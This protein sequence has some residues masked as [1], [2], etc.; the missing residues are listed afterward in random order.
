MKENMSEG[1]SSWWNQTRAA[2]ARI[3]GHVEVRQVGLSA[4]RLADSHSQADAVV[5]PA[6]AAGARENGW[7]PATGTQKWQPPAVSL[8]GGDLNEAALPCLVSGSLVPHLPET[9]VQREEARF[10]APTIWAADIGT[11]SSGAAAVLPASVRLSGGQVCLLSAA[12][13]VPPVHAV[14]VELSGRSRLG[15]VRDKRSGIPIFGAPRTWSRLDRIT[16][17]PL[18]RRRTALRAGAGVEGRFLAERQAL[19]ASCGATV[20]EVQLVASFPHVPL[21]LVQQMAVTPDGNALRLWLRPEALASGGAWT[22]A[23]VTIVLGRRRLTGET[24]RTVL[25]EAPTA[26][27]KR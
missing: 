6:P 5:W 26:G 22:A 15:A 8:A 14:S 7:L 23:R 1:S 18:L 4:P 20:E 11:N 17:V 13:L 19:A 12:L 16:R 2:L 9:G 10:P 27:R 24:I 3:F 25:P 21:V